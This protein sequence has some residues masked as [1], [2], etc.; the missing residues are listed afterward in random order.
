M[1]TV[2]RRHRGDLVKLVIFTVFSA[3]VASYLFI[4]TG[5]VRSGD[6]AEYHATFTDVSGLEKGDDVRVASVSVGRVKAVDIKPDSRVEVAFDLQSDIELTRA[7]TATVRYK[8]LIGDRYLSLERPDGSPGGRLAP[9]STI[10]TDRTAA[11]L[12]L[13]TLL[14]GFK[15]LFVGLNPQQINTLSE[16]LV[17]V[18]QGQSTAVTTLVSTVSS[19]TTTIGDRDRLVGQVIDNLNT[20]L[21]TLDGR[22]EALGSVVDQLST[23]VNGLDEQGPELTRA[24]TRIDGL[25]ADASDLLG[26]ARTDITPSLR[27][28]QG[29]ATT[30]HEHRDYLQELLDAYPEHY[31]RV[32]RT[33]SYGNFFNFFLCGVRLRLT[34]ENDNSSAVVTPWINSDIARCK[35]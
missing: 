12:N 16:Q 9:G 24:L 5:N 20:V 22:D 21:G 1:F 8:N 34:P 13:D 26:V 31:K 29:V 25:A 18:L 4:I 6:R 3:V 23:L 19:F 2:Q 28:L 17:Q 15:P 32:L 35:R 7:T 14:N 27:S 10:S 11:A 30:L 33:G